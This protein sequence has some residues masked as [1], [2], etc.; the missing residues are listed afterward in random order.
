[1]AY[2]YRSR[3]QA[4]KLLRYPNSD[5][6]KQRRH[7]RDEHT[8]PNP[9]MLA[10]IQEVR[11][12]THLPAGNQLLYYSGPRR[13]RR[14]RRRMAVVS[15]AT[16][17]FATAKSYVPGVGPP[18]VRFDTTGGSVCLSVWHCWHGFILHARDALGP[19]DDDDDDD[20]QPGHTFPLPSLS[21]KEQDS[22]SL[23][24]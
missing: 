5:N 21:G 11:Q 10:A 15:A 12:I 3:T 7:T 9:S 13:R 23:T 20:D 4:V 18:L 2:L 14:R 17:T 19:D 6:L 8:R 16:G 22:S 1:M 24:L